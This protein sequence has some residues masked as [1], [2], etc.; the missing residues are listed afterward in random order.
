MINIKLSD[1]QV[2]SPETDDMGRTWVG[3]SHTSTPQQLFDQNR[4]VWQLGTR[5]E[6]E[7]LVTFSYDGRVC[8]VAGIDGIETIPAKGPGRDKRALIG[9]VLQPG[10]PAHDALIGTA[11]DKHR[12]PV[13][14][15]QE[16]HVCPC[17]CGQSVAGHRV[18][19]SGHDQRAIH[20][21]IARQ[22]GNTLGFIRWFDTAY[23]SL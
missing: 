18:F 13:T 2:R 15:G 6:V 3:Y 19:V 17:G 1:R 16:P 11:T 23:P 5:A 7:Q 14:Y 4:G 22:W 9:R 10:D 8:V 12:N 20:D 21:R